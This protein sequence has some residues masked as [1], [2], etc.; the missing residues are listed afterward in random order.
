MKTFEK[1]FPAEESIMHE[2]VAYV[3]EILD[4]ID[5]DMKTSMRMAISVEEIFIN[6]ARYGYPGNAEG[7]A[8]I[9]LTLDDDGM[10]S[11]SFADAGVPFNP[12]EHE[13]P[14]ITLS[15]EERGIG[16]LGIFMVRKWADDVLY[17]YTEGENR[18][19]ILKRIG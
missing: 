17:T 9:T 12:L 11:V 13:D 8:R 10:L 6:I 19:T 2:V 18:L 3:E 4:Q 14:D 5:C 7:Y 16:G 1:V 15:A